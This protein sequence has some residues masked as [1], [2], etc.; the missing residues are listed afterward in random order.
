MATVYAPTSLQA[1]IRAAVV[2]G[3]NPRER[4]PLDDEAVLVHPCR[5]LPACSIVT[6]SRLVFNCHMFQN[7]VLFVC[8][9]TW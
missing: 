8:E 7:H 3:L 2:H 4:D 9:N 6:C 5:V 1:K